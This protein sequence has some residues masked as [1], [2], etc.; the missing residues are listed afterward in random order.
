LLHYLAPEITVADPA[1]ESTD[2]FVRF[3]HRS[4]GSQIW[5]DSLLFND[6]SGAAQ[7]WVLGIRRRF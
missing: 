6:V 3:H 1:W 7:Y 5:G 4:G 2:L